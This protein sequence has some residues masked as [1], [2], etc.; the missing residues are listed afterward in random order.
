MA[1]QIDDSPLATIRRV[2]ADNGCDPAQA[3]DFA[4][5]ICS[6]FVGERVYFAARP[7][8]TLAERD[9]QIRAAARSGISTRALAKDYCI[10][11]STVHRILTD[12]RRAAA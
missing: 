5:L 9:E 11:K 6:E 3:A 8:H 10:S 1:A 4:S 7:W 2:L 12:D